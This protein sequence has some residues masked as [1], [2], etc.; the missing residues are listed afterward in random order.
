MTTSRI[1]G[2]YKVTDDRPSYDSFDLITDNPIEAVWEA[3]KFPNNRTIVNICG[4]RQF[5]NTDGI[6]RIKKI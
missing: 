1:I 3:N 4:E 5:D 6:W 2:K